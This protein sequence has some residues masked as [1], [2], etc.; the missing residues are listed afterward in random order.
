[1]WGSLVTLMVKNLPAMQE[2]WVQSLGQE[3][4]PKFHGQ[5]SLEG[6]RAAKAETTGQ[7]TL[8]EIFNLSPMYENP[9]FTVILPQKGLH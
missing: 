9:H 4:L 5:R 6:Y 8:S 2:T 3:D 1:M 7:L